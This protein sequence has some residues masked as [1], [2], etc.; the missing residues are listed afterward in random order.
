MFG[1]QH[2]SI[3]LASSSSEEKEFSFWVSRNSTAL[4][5]FDGRRNSS[6]SWNRQ[7]KEV[8]RRMF[9]GYRHV[10]V[11]S[12]MEFYYPVVMANSSSSSAPPFPSSAPRL[13]FCTAFPRF[14]LDDAAFFVDFICDYL[15]DFGLTY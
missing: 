10:F 12:T 8:S 3:Y 15:E 13:L 5:K 4:G 1:C 9:Q 7:K 2:L 14:V 11:P 6:T